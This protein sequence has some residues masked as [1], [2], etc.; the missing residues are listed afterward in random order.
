MPKALEGVLEVFDV[1]NNTKRILVLLDLDGKQLDDHSKRILYIIKKFVSDAEFVPLEKHENA[2]AVQS[3]AS[4]LRIALHIANYRCDEHCDDKNKFKIATIDDYVLNLAFR[5]TTAQGLLESCRRDGWT[6]TPEKLI[7]K[8]KRELPRCLTR[9]GIPLKPEAKEYVKLYGAVLSLAI[10]PNRFA[11]KTL[12][13][14][15]KED[16]QKVF[17]SL[18]AA[19]KFLEN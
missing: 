8:I 9:N 5:E 2:F 19:I 13:H 7:A 15:K 10:S 17:A 1:S 12:A 14:A 11:A 18:I 16:I 6:I 4:N 3:S